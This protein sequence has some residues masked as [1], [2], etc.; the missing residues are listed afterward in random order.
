MPTG[1]RG[2]WADDKIVRL[3]LAARTSGE[4]GRLPVDGRRAARCGSRR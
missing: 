3:G 2:Q 1:R 4:M